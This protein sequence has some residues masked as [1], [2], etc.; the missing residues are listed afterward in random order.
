M[1]ALNALLAVTLFAPPPPPAPSAGPAGADPPRP[2]PAPA[3]VVP[4]GPN[5]EALRSAAA[6]RLPVRPK[7]VARWVRRARVAALLPEASVSYDLRVDKA[8]EFD[9]L[10][11]GSADNLTEDLQN[12]SVVRFRLDWDLGRLIYSPDELRAARAAMDVVDWRTQAE[13]DVAA[14][15]FERARLL[16]EPQS[17]ETQL[18][19]AEIES[20]LETLTGLAF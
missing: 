10:P 1:N 18:R 15:Y 16:L 6:A 5:L 12:V 19:I 8:W 14:L 11:D 2:A 9:Q 7:T 13:L 4:R 17:A 20:V 3:V